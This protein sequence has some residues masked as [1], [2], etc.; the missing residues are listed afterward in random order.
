MLV[1]ITWTTGWHLLMPCWAY[2]EEIYQWR[3]TRNVWEL[4]KKSIGDTVLSEKLHVRTGPTTCRHYEQRRS[5]PC[6]CR[7]L[8]TG[9]H[10]RGHQLASETGLFC[11]SP[12]FVLHVFRIVWIWVRIHLS[13][14]LSTSVFV[15]GRIHW[16]GPSDHRMHDESQ[17]VRCQ[18]TDRYIKQE[19]WKF[20]LTGPTHW[21]GLCFFSFVKE[22]KFIFD[23]DLMSQLMKLML[24]KFRFFLSPATYI[25]D[26]HIF[27]WNG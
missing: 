1:R 25:N 16:F 4:H 13:P 21:N 12:S 14:I 8:F 24:L 26:L 20:R 19:V 17:R 9:A 27:V 22:A 15:H 11:A 23:Y 3:S 5:V 18:E 6:S 2:S 10:L 7:R